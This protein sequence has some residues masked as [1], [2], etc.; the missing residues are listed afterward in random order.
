MIAGLFVTLPAQIVTFPAAGGILGD[1]CLELND[2]T[3]SGWKA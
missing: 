1:Q 3:L 2:T